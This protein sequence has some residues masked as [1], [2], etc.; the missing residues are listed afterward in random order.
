[1]GLWPKQPE[2]EFEAAIQ[3]LEETWPWGKAAR[4]EEVDRPRWLRNYIYE[5]VTGYGERPWRPV[6]WGWVTILVFAV[7]YALAGNIASTGAEAASALDIH[8]WV[9]AITHS[10]AAFTTIGFN[11]LEPIGWGARMLTALESGLGHRS[12]RPLYLHHRQPH[13]PV[14]TSRHWVAR[15]G[16]HLVLEGVLGLRPALRP[17]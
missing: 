13:V 9:T 4:E 8:R 12:F 16:R 7:I 14:V 17:S 11:T 15:R 5:L 2:D 6:G 3:A 1:M 10:V